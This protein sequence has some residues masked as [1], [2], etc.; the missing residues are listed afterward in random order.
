ARHLRQAEDPVA[1]ATYAMDSHH[2]S[3]F[4]DAHG[5]LWLEGGYGMSL[6]ARPMP[7]SYRSIVPRRG[8]TTNLLVPV[9]CSAS[10]AAYGPPRMEPVFMMLG[11]SAATAACL[12]IDAGVAVQDL[13]YPALRA[14]L[15]A[16]GLVLE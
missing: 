14:R 12:A 6:K 9:C 10:H 1:L 8:E 13:P 5:K 2:V 11:Q 4:V 7:L 3:R 16:D 15:L